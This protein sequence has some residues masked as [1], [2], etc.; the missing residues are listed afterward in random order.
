LLPA[1]VEPLENVTVLTARVVERRVVGNLS[2][3]SAVGLL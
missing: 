2:R 3:C 1:L